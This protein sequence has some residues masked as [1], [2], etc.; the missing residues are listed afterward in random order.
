VYLDPRE[1]SGVVVVLG[2]WNLTETAD[3]ASA[4]HG[5]NVRDGLGT[6]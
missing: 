4:V 3:N 1:L 2:I 5:P 6:L